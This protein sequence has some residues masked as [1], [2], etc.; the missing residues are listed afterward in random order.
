MRKVI[1][2]MHVSLDGFVAGP[3]GEMDWIIVNEEMYEGVNKI[4][5][6]VDT[7]IYGRVTYGMMESYWPTIPSNPSSS[8]LE[9]KHAEWVEKVH[10][11]VFSRTLDKVEWNNTRLI[12]ENISEEMAKLKQKEGK[13]MMIFGSPGLSH[14]FMS[15]GLIDEYRLNI[16]PVILGEGIPLFKNIDGKINL[17]L[18]E[19]EQLK[20]GVVGLHY[21]SVRR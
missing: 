19:S 15:L 11:I 17:R 14:T 21:E 9:R 20:S 16:N 2:L 5:E 13:N 7:P 8:A 18:L 10:K 3:N 6:D 12:K 1:L 4:L